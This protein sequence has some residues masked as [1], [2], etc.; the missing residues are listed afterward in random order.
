GKFQFASHVKS[1]TAQ[2]VIPMSDARTGKTIRYRLEPFVPMVSHSNE[3][4]GSPEQIPFRFP[5]G[6]LT[7]T[8]VHPDGTRADLG[9][10]P[11]LQN[12]TRTPTTVSGAPISASSSHVSDLFELT[13][14]DPR[15][16][17]TFTQY[18]VYHVLMSGTIEDIYGNV[19]DGGGTYE[20]TIA[21]TL[22]LDTGV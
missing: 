6:N 17:Y 14:L 1:N 12:M 18:G 3:R 21:R 7:V 8:V 4:I 9:S 2:F 20:V 22:S 15:F 5:S 16:Q 11:F 19:Y 13:T 10:A